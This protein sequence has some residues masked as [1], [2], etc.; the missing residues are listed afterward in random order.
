MNMSLL[1]RPDQ[2][3]IERIAAGLMVVNTRC[4]GTDLTGVQ[5]YTLEIL[6]RLSLAH[7]E[8]SPRCF[9][10]GFAG[11]LWEQAVLPLKLRRD[12]LLWSPSNCGPLA[13]RNQVVTVHDLA[14]IDHPEW[15]TKRFALWYQMI[16]PRLVHRVRHIITV[17][18]FTRNRLI[19]ALQVPAGKITVIYNGV[20]RRFCPLSPARRASQAVEAM[21]LPSSRYVLS[22]CSIGQRKNIVR[23]LKAWEQIEGRYK[24][25]WLVIAGAE[26]SELV[27]DK[28]FDDAQC[29]EPVEP[30]LH[31]QPVVSEPVLSAIEGVE[32]LPPRVH[33]T[34]H[35]PEEYLA[36]LYAGAIVYVYVSL[37]EGF[38]LP[39]LE[40]MAAGCPAIVSKTTALPEVC[41]DAAFYVD[42]CD[43]EAIAKAMS[44]V[45]AEP[46][47]RRMLT[48]RGLARA[49]D[50]TWD[51]SARLHEKVFETF[52][53]NQ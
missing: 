46:D 19:D 34:G 24:D 6:K 17:S 1:R 16:V 38:G 49:S 25:I 48:G 20:D 9:S 36:A 43:V 29:G 32:P 7:L 23:L 44:D 2:N 52:L 18:E 27:F 35:V 3:R 51:K 12:N 26:G 5:R 41:K 22:L 45:I 53:H 14:P 21:K 39:P 28:H 40:A 15:F 10:R 8:L 33:F 4:L 11:H 13:V 47:R 50:F 42:P 37:Y 31:R 30:V